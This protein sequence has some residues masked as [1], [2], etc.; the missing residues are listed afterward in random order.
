MNGALEV[1]NTENNQ[2]L[3]RCEHYIPTN[4]DMDATCRNYGEI[5]KKFETQADERAQNNKQA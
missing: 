5:I 2:L 3:G 1:W 4:I